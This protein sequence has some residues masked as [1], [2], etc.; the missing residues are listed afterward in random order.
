MH[1]RAEPAQALV[2]LLGSVGLCRHFYQ[3]QLFISAGLSEIL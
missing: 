3:S 2:F 1:R